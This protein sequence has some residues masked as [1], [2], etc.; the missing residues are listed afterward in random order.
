MKVETKRL[1]IRSGDEVVV[2]AGSA[3]GRRGKVKEV[4]NKKAAV[5]L[6]GSEQRERREAPS[7]EAGPASSHQEPAEPGR[8]APL[9]GGLH[10]F[11]ERDESRGIRTPEREAFQRN[12]IIS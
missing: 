12:P 5:V 10:P 4:L 3:K 9:V 2:I 11:L 1:H 8:R 6:E 7:G